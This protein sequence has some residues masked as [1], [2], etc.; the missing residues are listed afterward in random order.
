[1]TIELVT[2]RS[3]K[4]IIAKKNVTFRF[5]SSPILTQIEI[6]IFQSK[7]VVDRS[8]F[9]IFVCYFFFS[10]PARKTPFH[11]FVHF[12]VSHGIDRLLQK[13]N[14]FEFTGYFP[15]FLRK[16]RDIPQP[17][18]LQR[19]SA[20]Y[21]LQTWHAWTNQIC[22]RSFRWMTTHSVWFKGSQREN[23]VNWNLPPLLFL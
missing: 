15:L 1:M 6:I 18:T 14:L 12:V 21:F 11:A 3:R 13:K 8:Y 22:L 23:Y 4:P 9:F 2:F 20:I 7:I 19:H 5:L 16:M 17:V 10:I